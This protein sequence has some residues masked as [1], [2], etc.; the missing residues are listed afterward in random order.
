MTGSR[1]LALSTGASLLGVTVGTLESGPKAR[2]EVFTPVL[3]P[4]VLAL[5]SRGL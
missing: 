4:G 2:E 5:D 3:A 1:V